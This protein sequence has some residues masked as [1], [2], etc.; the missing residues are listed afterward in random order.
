M[1]VF[2]SG[3]N[4]KGIKVRYPIVNVSSPYNII[5]RRSSFNAL[6][7]DMSTLYLTMKYPLEVGQVRIIKGD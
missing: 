7:V 5:I 1:A 6:E 3:S 4:T 2:G